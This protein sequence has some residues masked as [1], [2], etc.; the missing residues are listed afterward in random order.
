MW[1]ESMDALIMQIVDLLRARTS[2]EEIVQQ[3]NDS[4]GNVAATP[5]ELPVMQAVSAAAAAQLNG[6]QLS[7]TELPM[8]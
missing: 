8:Q 2:T 7:G 5:V 3:L 6:G 4:G 1:R